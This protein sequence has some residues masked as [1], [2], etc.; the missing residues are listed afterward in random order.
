MVRHSDCL[1]NISRKPN[2][3]L[4]SGIMFGLYGV[5]Y[6]VLVTGLIYMSEIFVI[7]ISQYVTDQMQMC[8]V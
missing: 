7:S 8:P 3:S 4:K 2:T 5:L 1:Y 6:L